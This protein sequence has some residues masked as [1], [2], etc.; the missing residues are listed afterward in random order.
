LIARIVASEPEPPESEQMEEVN[1]IVPLQIESPWPAERL[2][3]GIRSTVILP[4][5]VFPLPPVAV[6]KGDAV[7][8][9]PVPYAIGDLKLVRQRL[10]RYELGEVSGI[11]NVMRGEYKESS[12]KRLREL[13][14][15]ELESDSNEQQAARELSGQRQDLLAET[16][17]TLKENFQYHYESQYGPPAKQ[18]TVIVDGTVQPVDGEPQKTAN[19]DAISAARLLTQRAAGSMARRLHW[20]RSSASINRDEVCTLR[21]IDAGQMETNVR[22]IYRWVNKVYQCWTVALGKRFILE[23]FVRNPA[24]GYIAGSF[25]LRGLS[26]RE[27]PALI[28]FGVKTFQDISIDPESPAYYAKL[29]AEYDVVEL[30]PPPELHS[31]SSIAFQGGEPVC[32]QSIPVASGYRAASAKVAVSPAPGDDSLQLSVSVGQQRYE[33]PPGDGDSG[34]AAL[35]LDGQ[36]GLVPAAVLSRQAKQTTQD[37]KALQISAGYSVAIEIKADLSEQALDQWKLAT[38]KS[39]AAGCARAR[40]LYYEMVGAWPSQLQQP[41]SLSIRELVRSELRRDIV[42]QLIRHVE[43]LTGESG[44]IALGRERYVQFLERALAWG[45]MAYAFTVKTEDDIGT[46]ISQQY[47]G[48]DELFSAFLQA[49]SSRVLLPVTPDFAYRMLYFLA[50]GQIWPGVDSLT[51]TFCPEE[52]S[53]P[54]YH[55][56]NLVNALKESADCESA[57]ERQETWE[58]VV[59]TNMTVLQ[60]GSQLPVFE[61]E[62]L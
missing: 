14:T 37:A 47:R 51:P 8:I 13:R 39:I 6:G 57:T 44:N 42:R 52:K 19:S 38:F 50:S 43:T 20:Q 18:L 40:E 35:Q 5:S 12:E 54:D 60:E 31:L 46:S 33:Y 34:T 22:A 25:S 27:P 9:S 55:Y 28:D 11:E 24:Q 17:N 7:D 49:G 53:A 4:G 48:E 10:R 26:L 23:F 15:E 32:G 58:L 59:P 41:S 1:E 21:R 2:D 16:L 61:G 3:A 30:Q 56:I 45:E 29:A 62:E 36:T